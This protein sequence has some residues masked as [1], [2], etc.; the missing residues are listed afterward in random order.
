VPGADAAARALG[1]QVLD[2]Q[3]H[4]GHGLGGDIAEGMPPRRGE[5]VLVGLLIVDTRWCKAGSEGSTHGIVKR[6]KL[7]Q[8]NR[9]RGRR[10][11]RLWS[12]CVCS[13]S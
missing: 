11:R 4:V 1:P 7:M 10:G 13:R 9:S 3:R 2:V 12:R 8:Y 5:E 6:P